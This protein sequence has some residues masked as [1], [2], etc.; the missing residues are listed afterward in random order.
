MRH[1]LDGPA[2]KPVSRD[3]GEGGAPEAIPHDEICDLED[4][5]WTERLLGWLA[6]PGLSG[7]AREEIV[8][9][10]VVLDD[11]RAEAPLTGL[12]E[13][14]ALPDE[15][16]AGA[17]RVLLGCGHVPAAPT[18]R[19][20]W[21][22]EDLVLRRHALRAMDLPEADLIAPVASDPEHPLHLDAICALDFDCEEP[23]LL[24]MKIAA[25]GHADPR[26][27]K[28]AAD[29]LAWDEPSIAEEELLLATGDADAEVAA[30]ALKTLAAYPSQRCLRAVDALRRHASDRVQMEAEHTLRELCGPYSGFSFDGLSPAARQHVGSWMAPVRDLVA[31]GSEPEEH[32]LLAPEIIFSGGRASPPSPALEDVAQGSA[33]ALPG[34]APQGEPSEDALSTEAL[35]ALYADLDG[36]WWERKDR[37]Q[38]RFE[39][40]RHLAERQRVVAFLTAHPDRWVRGGAAQLFAGWNEVEALVRLTRD[41]NDLVRTSAIYWLCEVAPTPALAGLLWEH[42]Q[43]PT[44]LRAHAVKTLSSYLM[45]A[46]PEEA[47]PRLVTLVRE[48]RREGVRCAAVEGL[49]N[50][51]A[52]AEVQALL[53]LLAEPPRVTWDVHLAL[54]HVCEKLGVH[55]GK[56]DAL[57][58]VD[59]AHVQAAIAPWMVTVAPVVAPGE[60]AGT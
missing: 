4:R 27:R 3:E 51:D 38:V 55:P 10:L 8:E 12:L 30:A 25:L 56:L 19:R 5:S 57:R 31:A 42:L 48:D 46:R 50:L 2:G 52:V 60:R 34:E 13:A 45:H 32:A 6:E 14:A 16:R 33:G 23:R 40:A 35:L 20:Y 44:T 36:P 26:V 1:P 29:A 21:A 28:A 7:A 37:F 41:R 49:G 9:T 39:D 17:G 43:A 18:L 24:V 53:P 22:G 59:H 47:L 11:P 15:V 58:E 54:L